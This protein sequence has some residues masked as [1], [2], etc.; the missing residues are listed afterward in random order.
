MLNYSFDV[1]DIT[2]SCNAADCLMTNLTKL[3]G[4]YFGM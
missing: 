3:V 1:F 4:E 2:V